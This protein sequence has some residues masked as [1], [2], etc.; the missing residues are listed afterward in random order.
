MFSSA[1]T[2]AGGFV[3]SAIVRK[4]LSQDEGV[5][6]SNYIRAIA[7]RPLTI[8]SSSHLQTKLVDLSSKDAVTPRLFEGCDVVFHVASK[9]AMWGNSE[10]FEK[11]NV[12]VTRM[13]LHAAAAAGV[14][15]FVYTSSPSVIA[16]GE[17]LKGVD[18]T[19]PYPKHYLAE[20][21]KT[22]A[23]AERLV[24]AADKVGGMRTL[25]LRPH[26]IFGPG[27]TSLGPAILARAKAGSLVRLG[28]RNPLVDFTYIDDCVDAHLVGAR[29]LLNTPDL[30]AGKAYFI[31][32]GEPTPFWDWVNAFIA[33]YNQPAITKQIPVKV[34]YSVASLCEVACRLFPFLGEPR[35]TRF[36][37]KEMSTDH[38]FSIERARNLLGFQPSCTVAEGIKKTA[39]ALV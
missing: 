12:G 38:Y 20:Y 5:E 25:A 2:G 36:L 3:G 27:D 21:P 34:A 14:K 11:Q 22:K 30:V 1:V 7:R 26:L 9:V 39:M 17:D 10:D 28:S 16:G 6:H 13:V 23:I 37:V 8:H 32:Q 29:A 35:I 31:S 33:I 24:L 15:A 19:Y 18:E 4:L